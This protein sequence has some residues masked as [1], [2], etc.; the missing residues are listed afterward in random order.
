MSSSPTKITTCWCTSI[1]GEESPRL[2]LLLGNKSNTYVGDLHTCRRC[3]PL[4]RATLRLCSIRCSDYIHSSGGLGGDINRERLADS[5]GMCPGS[6]SGRVA[7]SKAEDMGSNLCPSTNF[8][9][10]CIIICAVDLNLFAHRD[11]MGIFSY[12]FGLTQS[13]K[14]VRHSW[15]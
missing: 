8:S 2:C 5:L 13:L 11:G 12:T 9:L 10:E 7:A 3:F 14:L 15:N 6:S 1:A 4:Y